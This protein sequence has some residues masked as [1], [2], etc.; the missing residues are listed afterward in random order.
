MIL[1]QHLCYDLF[2]KS[3]EIKDTQLTSEA[4]HVL[5]NF[6]CSCFSESKFILVVV[7]PRNYIHKSIYSKGIM[8]CGNG[9]Y[10]F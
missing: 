1:F 4:F 9:A 8:L 7:K 3:A 6:V 2:V 5:D 10:L